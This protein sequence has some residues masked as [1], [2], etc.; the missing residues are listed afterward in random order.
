M[1]RTSWSKI[2][3]WL[4]FAAGIFVAQPATAATSEQIETAV[5]NGLAWLATQQQEDGSWLYGGEADPCVD[6]ATMALVVLKFEDRAKE[7]DK[8]PFDTGDYEYA[9]NVI[10]GLNYIFG[11]ALSDP[12]G[13]TFP[14]LETYSTGTALMAISAS[15]APIRVIATG[16]LAGSD[17]ESAA[18]GMLNWLSYAQ[19]TA[20]DTSTCDVGG[21]GYA[22]LQDGFSDQ[23]NS[24]YAT[25]GLGF[26]A[27]PAPAGFELTIPAD[28]LSRLG[29]YIDNVQ[30]PTDGDIN[31]YDGGSWYEPCNVY[32]WV[33]ILKTGNL[34]YEMGLVGD[35][36]ATSTRVQNAIAYIEAH[37]NDTG[38]QPEFTDTSLGW[39]DAY[40][41]MFTMMKGL[42]ALGI[43]TLTVGGFDIDW[44]DEVSDIIVANQAEDGSMD[45]LTTPPYGEGE[46]SVNLRTAW[47][48]LTLERVVP[49]FDIPVA[50]DIHPTSCPNPINV[51]SKGLTP[52]AILGTESF[53][54]ATVDP[55]TVLLQGVEPIRWAYDDVATP[56]EPYL[57]KEGAHACNELWGDGFLDLTLKFDTRELAAAFGEVSDGEVLAVPLTGNLKAEFG[58]TP[59]VGEDVVI[60]LEKGKK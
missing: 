46:V 13:V 50:V 51:G 38:P 11:Q 53:D 52:V 47:A 7:L 3:L 57:G 10:D 5:A 16:P 30:D 34:L 35:D 48:L 23:S 54:V 42:E 26:A 60:I 32:K 29:Q 39:K 4:A 56:Y 37:W 25:L 58:G 31:G 55:A 22:A 43:E 17:Y 40:Q 12:N 1:N 59:I 45:A 33:N 2:T 15:N 49:Q 18:D 8:D 36:P 20:D 28:V 19:N 24:G 27:A 44:F 14:C 6:V 9:S 21:W 41:A